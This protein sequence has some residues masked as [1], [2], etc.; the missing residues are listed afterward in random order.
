MDI[1]ISTLQFVIIILVCEFISYKYIKI[2]D[3]KSR[4]N[5]YK[6]EKNNIKRLA[7]ERKK[8]NDN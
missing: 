3:K 8:I 5:I 1:L 2:I 4:E 7:E 6:W